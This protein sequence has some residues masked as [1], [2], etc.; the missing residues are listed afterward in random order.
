MSTSPKKININDS[1]YNI[2]I[3][4]KYKKSSSAKLNGNKIILRI[5]DSVSKKTQQEHIDYLID[6]IS[7]KIIKRDIKPDPVILD[8]TI[9]FDIAGKTYK[10]EF[11]NEDR[12][13]CR[14]DLKEGPII[15]FTLPYYK[16]YPKVIIKDA[17]KKGLFKAISQDN[18]DFITDLILYTNNKH[19]KHKIKDV[20]V[21]PLLSKWG[22]CNSFNEITINTLLLFAPLEVL[23]YIIVHELAHINMLNH[24]KQYWSIVD[25]IV[26]ERKE[27]EAWLKKYGCDLLS[28]DI[29]F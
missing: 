13:T 12:M 27:R 20:V 22:E 4:Y 19:F 14:V 29:V 16:C 24:S 21:K 3:E 15:K 6:S 26:P 23:E 9:G 17:V 1:D 10:T 2:V 25:K 8:L 18:H 5:S 28:L 7:K 11:V